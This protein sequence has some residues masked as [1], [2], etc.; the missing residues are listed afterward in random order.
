M[1]IL[2]LGYD[3]FDDVNQ[4]CTVH[5]LA[6]DGNTTLDEYSLNISTSGVVTKEELSTVAISTIVGFI[7][8]GLTAGDVADFGNS[9]AV[10]ANPS[11]TLNSAFQI[12][13]ERDVQVA[14][15]VNI[16]CAS[17]ALA[18]QK[19]RATLKYADDSGIT[20][21]VV[22]VCEIENSTGPLLGLSNGNTQVL[23]GR[24]PAGKYVK[25]VPD[26]VTGTPTITFVRSQEV[27]L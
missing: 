12:S 20:T 5:S 27:L 18:G 7:G 13:T 22:S 4:T 24:I 14:Y 10:Y 16:L 11:R 25:I 8:G 9:P 3:N 6:Y 17:S 1:K 23:A 26:Q 2:I 21:N 19:G 15:S